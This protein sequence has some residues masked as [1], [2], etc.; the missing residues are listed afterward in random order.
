MNLAVHEWKM[1][2]EALNPVINNGAMSIRHME[3]AILVIMDKIKE[4]YNQPIQVEKK[5]PM[6]V[7][8]GLTQKYGSRESSRDFVFQDICIGCNIKENK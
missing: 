1:I 7:R 8:C 4:R 3:G 6:C 2:H 5:E